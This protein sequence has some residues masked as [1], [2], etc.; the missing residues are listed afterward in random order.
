MLNTKVGKA[1][2]MIKLIKDLPDRF[3]KKTANFFK[4]RLLKY[5]RKKI[6]L[7]S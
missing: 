2:E 5:I 7:Y 6:Y 3:K 4:I 1:Y